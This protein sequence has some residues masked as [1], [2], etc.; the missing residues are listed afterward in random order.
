MDLKILKDSIENKQSIP[1]LIIFRGAHTFIANQYISAILKLKK[2]SLE[3][4]EDLEFV[5][6]KELDIFNMHTADPTLKFYKVDN[7][8]Y[9]GSSLLTDN[10]IIVLCKKLDNH[11]AVEYKDYII[12]LNELEEWQ[13]QDYLYSI[14]DGID[15]ELIDWLINRFDKNI[16]RLQL[17]ADKLLLFNPNERNILLNQMIEDNAFSDSSEDNI[18]DFTDSLCKRDLTRLCN[19]YKNINV[20]D[21]EAIGVHTIMYKNFI[22]LLQVWLANNPTPESTNLSSKQ[23]YAISRLPRVWSAESLISIVEFLTGIDYKIKTG[24]L[25]VPLLRD[26]IVVNILSR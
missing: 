17:E 10:M 15:R 13:I 23:I 21:I 26:Y 1:N 8:V 2:L 16:D 4:V 5:N 18:F 25:P 19:I 14:L 20:I 22:K 3:Y 12:D 9:E 6:S 24:A 7:F 11:L